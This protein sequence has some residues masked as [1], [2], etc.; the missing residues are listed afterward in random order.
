MFLRKRRKERAD[1]ANYKELGKLRENLPLTTHYS[2]LTTHNGNSGQNLLS[3]NPIAVLL[4]D[5]CLMH[6]PIA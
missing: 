2:P 6:L 3:Q 1:E 5:I 4:D